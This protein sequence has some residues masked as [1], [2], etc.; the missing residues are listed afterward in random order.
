MVEALVVAQNQPMLEEPQRTVVSEFVS[1][2]I[3]QY[4]MS[5]NQPWGMPY[6]FIPDG[7]IPPVSEVPRATMNMHPP[8]G[9]RPLEIEIPRETAMGYAQQNVEILRSV[10]MASPQP[11]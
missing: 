8:E 5:P 9:Y 1:T 2:P 10:V 7:Y 11:I 6:N 4:T 3:P